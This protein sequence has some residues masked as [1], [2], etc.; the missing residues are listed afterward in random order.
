[1]HTITRPLRRITKYAAD[2]AA[3]RNVT[4][5]S[6][7]TGGEIGELLASVNTMV[8]SIARR[9]RETREKS[10]E[11]ARQTNMART[12]LEESR[13]QERKVGDL[14]ATM[15]HVSQEAQSIAEEVANASQECARNLKDVGGRVAENDQRIQSVVEIMQRMRNHAQSM[16][17]SAT[18]ATDST[19]TAKKSAGKGDA[20]LTQA[21][22]AIDTVSAQTDALR[23]KLELL[24]EKAEAI[25][26][27]MTVINDIAD[28][29]N[30]LALNAAIEAAR[31]GEAGRGFAVVADEVRKL[32]EKT[33]QA[34]GDVARNITEIQNAAKGSIDG[35]G[36]TLAGV[37]EA[38]ERT[39]ESGKELDAIVASVDASALRVQDIAGVAKEQDATVQEVI[40]AV[41]RSS[42]AT[43]TAVADIKDMTGSVQN[44][45]TRATDLHR[46]VGELA[47]T[48]SKT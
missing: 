20:T 43:R 11:T 5:P 10:E 40:D 32:A 33:M 24:G 42:E 37:K 19:V 15:L 47:S 44:L 48:G 45:T 35:M 46:L 39:R 16:I 25:G 36:T 1:V 6:L 22:S 30:L 12:A 7:D 29:T 14:V 34:T 3:E 2:V 23:G 26:T 8:D 27:I 21:V 28:Q 18:T 38:T 31:A 41:A 17:A 4:A 13:M 9:I